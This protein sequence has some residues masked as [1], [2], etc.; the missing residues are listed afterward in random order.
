MPQTTKNSKAETFENNLERLNKVVELM[1]SVDIPLEKA[2]ELYEEGMKL[3][4]VCQK[5]LEE[6]EGRVEIL[7]KRAENRLAAE[8]FDPAEKRQDE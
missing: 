7:R 4:A 3:S 8:R 6:A 2:L 1:E 5:Q